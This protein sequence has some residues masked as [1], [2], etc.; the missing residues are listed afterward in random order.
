[1]ITKPLDLLINN[2]TEI[3]ISR[4]RNKGRFTQWLLIVAKGH[5]VLRKCID[6]CVHNINKKSSINH[7]DKL[8]GPTVYTE[9]IKEVFE[10][11][12]YTINDNL[13]NIKYKDKNVTFYG[14]DYENFAKFKTKQSDLLYKNRVHWIQEQSTNKVVN[15]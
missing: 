1:M 10:K 4:E 5:D 2:H 11:D 15:L 13:L 6:K 12:I 9:A 14:F 7:V 8:T 3:I